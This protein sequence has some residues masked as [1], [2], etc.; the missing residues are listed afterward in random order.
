MSL[1]ISGATVIDGN[2][3]RPIEGQSIWIEAG[4]IKAIGRHDQMAVPSSIKVLDAR[5]KY[6]IPGLMDANVHL[7]GD[8]RIEQLVR[9]EGRYEEL[10]LESA[11]VALKSGLTSVFDTWGPR[12]ALM[13]VRDNIS[14]GKTVGSRIFCAGNIIGLDGPISPDFLPKVV[15]LVSNSLV[16]RINSLYAENVGPDLTWM[17]PQQ[18]AEEVR[19]YLR[20]GIDFIKYASNE[21]RG[22]EPNAFL[23]FSPLVQSH[24][25][26]EAHRAGTTAQA[27]ATSVEGIRVAIEAGSDILQHCNLSGPVP[28]PEETLE[29][30]A[31]RK[32]GAVL[33]P[34]TE[35]R[36][37]IFKKVDVMTRR[38]WST[39]DINCR[40]LIG[41]GVPLLLGTDQSLLASDIGSDPSMKNNPIAVN[42]DNLFELGQGH[43]HW[44]TAM[45]E[46]GCPPMRILKAATRNIA[47]AYGK[48]QDLGSLEQGKIADMLILSGNPL[49]AAKNYRAI[50]TII[51][52]GQI[53]DTEALPINPILTKPTA[54][55]S[56][57]ASSYGRFA[58]SRYPFCCG[59]M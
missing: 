32:T 45:E 20:T 35:R 4:R 3:E 47:V 39:A 8:V 31:K 27:H 17:V 25:V 22:G 40:A 57:T 23:L 50:Q 42:E 26:E 14:S 11:Q 10:I 6:V 41:S 9:Y 51:K 33:F 29:L 52:D 34:L 44:L 36:L 15:G 1:L 13:A 59:S 37:E 16:E 19:A 2:A 53:V 18:V 55:A 24:I 21:H 7:M 46:K 38:F 12:M 58:P 54:P 43:F 56:D 48:D 30:L 28:I 5:G 49:Q